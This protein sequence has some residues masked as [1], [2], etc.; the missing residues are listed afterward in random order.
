MN[1]PLLA[2][3]NLARRPVRTLLTAGGVALAVA[4]AVSLG[5]FNLGYRRA[6][7]GSIEQLGFQVMVM[8]KG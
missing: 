7:A 4:V 8:A 3:R 6:I 5:G 2:W 1:F